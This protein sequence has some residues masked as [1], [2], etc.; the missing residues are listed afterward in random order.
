M[1]IK[2]LD[3][4][5]SVNCI[6]EAAN[7]SDIKSLVKFA[8]E[9]SEYLMRN[10]HLK[11]ENVNIKRCA[12]CLNALK[13]ADKGTDPRLDL[14]RMRAVGSLVQIGYPDAETLYMKAPIAE[15]KS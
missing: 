10:S 2:L 13:S 15:R 1:A 9:I 12:S 11:P 8:E 4:N 14:L 5:E 6:K 3:R 7:C